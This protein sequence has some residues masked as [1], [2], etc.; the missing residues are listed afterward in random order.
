MGYRM[1]RSYANE[2]GRMSK[3]C[4][5]WTLEDLCDMDDA[6]MQALLGFYRPNTVPSLDQLRLQE[7]PGVYHFDGSFG[8]AV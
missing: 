5:S 7:E 1:W 2:R 4:E 8:W 6:D 3:V